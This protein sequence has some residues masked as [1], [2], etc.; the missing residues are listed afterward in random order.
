[1][2][3]LVSIIIPA[4][5]EERYI[6]KTIESVLNNN[7]SNFE[8][9]VVC[10][11]CTDKTEQAVKRFKKFKNV[12]LSILKH[13][14]AS[15]ARNKGVQLAKG[16]LLIFLDADI[17]IS[18]NSIQIITDILVKHNII[19]TLKA[20]PDV[21]KFLPKLLLNLRDFLLFFHLYKTGNGII[22]CRKELFNLVK[23]FKE[24]LKKHE[25]GIFVRSAAKLS[26]FEYVSSS[27]VIQSMRRHEKIGYFNV[28]KYWTKDWLKQKLGKTDKDYPSIR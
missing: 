25:D 2:E 3:Q 14:D 26:K 27:Y 9:I 7:Y 13:K 22:F 17:N 24:N 23:G 11:G 5:N 19:G 16:N 12:K 1:M 21:N 10:N 6:E 8:I 4:F 18:K 20:V 15:T 28:M